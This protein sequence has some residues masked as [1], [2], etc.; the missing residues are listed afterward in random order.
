MALF[1]Q[2]PVPALGAQLRQEAQGSRSGPPIA[3]ASS[4]QSLKSGQRLGRW[5]WRR[6]A[7]RTGGGGVRQ[8]VVSKAHTHLRA[9]STQGVLEEKTQG[10]DL[11]SAT[12]RLCVFP[13]LSLDF[14]I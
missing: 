10:L 8:P 4:Q 14:L 12:F 7:R 2:R 9:R 1:T 5:A 6:A 13:S 3:K 11:G